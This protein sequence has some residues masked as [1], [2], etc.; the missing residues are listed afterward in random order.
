MMLG[1][2]REGIGGRTRP[3]GGERDGARGRGY[4]PSGKRWEQ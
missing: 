2:T 4:R 3:R 1:V